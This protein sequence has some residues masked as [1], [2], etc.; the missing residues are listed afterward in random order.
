MH[1]GVRG[2]CARGAWRAG[3]LEVSG[4]LSQPPNRHCLRS[5]GFQPL[6]QLPAAVGRRQAGCRRLSDPDS[7]A[8]GQFAH[9]EGLC[10]ANCTE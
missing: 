10:F 3:Y 1:G 8:V 6:D 5:P 4:A 2:D 9:V 7:L